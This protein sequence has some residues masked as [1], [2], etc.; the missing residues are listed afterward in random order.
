MVGVH[1]GHYVVGEE[2][3]GV[4]EEHCDENGGR[5]PLEREHVA[6]RVEALRDHA[7]AAI[8]EQEV[9]DERDARGHSL[10]VDRE[11]Q[12][13][14]LGLVGGAARVDE[15]R[16]ELEE[17]V[18][19]VAHGLEEQKVAAVVGLGGEHVREDADVERV[20]REAEHADG[21]VD[22]AVGERHHARACGRA[23]HR[24]D[25]G[26]IGG[27]ATRYQQIHGICYFLYF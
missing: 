9:D 11:H 1:V 24:V 8:D 10:A 16:P 2:L 17:C 6:P 4:Q 21:Q 23:R 14:H 15:E 19:G 12:V 20:E 7:Q 27:E 26:A 13:G 18:V 5:A 22:V 3:E 25:G